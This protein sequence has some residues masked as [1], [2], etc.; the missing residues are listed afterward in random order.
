MQ[1]WLDLL[2]FSELRYLYKGKLAKGFFTLVKINL[3]AFVLAFTIL[4]KPLPRT[5]EEQELQVYSTTA[6]HPAW[7][8]KAPSMP[9]QSGRPTTGNKLPA[10]NLTRL[11]Y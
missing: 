10:F 4:G 3:L 8:P 5:S 7:R 1:D 11:R 6:I 9:S 2:F